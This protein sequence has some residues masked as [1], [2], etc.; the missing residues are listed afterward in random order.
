MMLEVKGKSGTVNFDVDAA[1]EETTAALEMLISS[2]VKVIVDKDGAKLK[3]LLTAKPNTRSHSSQY[4][5]ENLEPPLLLPLGGEW[6]YSVALTEDAS[7][8]KSVQI[9]KG[10]IIGDF[11]KNPETGKV[12]LTPNDPLNPITKVNKI[13][14]KR[15]EEWAELQRPV[16]SRLK[17][18]KNAR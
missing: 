11:R 16:A 17:E 18:L 5:R 2:A 3:E 6:T 1:D 4:S 12:V 8:G 10:K 14:I 15:L 7:G 9:C 13:N